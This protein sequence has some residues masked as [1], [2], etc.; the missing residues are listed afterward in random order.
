MKKERGIT[1]IALIITIVV[2]L[3][4]AAV[5][6]S[7]IQNDGILSYAINA[8]KDYNQAAAN[9]QDMLQGY[10]NFL[11]NGG[12]GDGNGDGKL[13]VTAVKNQVLS[14]TENKEVYDVYGNR[15]ILPAGFKITTDA[16]KVTEGIVI[17]H[18]T[19]GNQFVWI[20]VGTINH[21][22]ADS[23]ATTTL[24]TLGRYKF[25][26]SDVTTDGVTIYAG[27]PSVYTG[28]YTEDTEATHT[29]TNA[30]A[31]NIEHFTASANSKG[32]YYIGRYEAGDSKNSAI[33]DRKGESGKTTEGVL[34]CK[35][36][37]VP[38]NWILQKDAS[39]LCKGMY[40]DG[41]KA[42]GTGTFSSDLINSY[43][44]D[45]AIVFIQTFG[46]DKTAV[47]ERNKS[48]KNYSNL[49]KS[50]SYTKTGANGDEY[51]NINDMSGNALEWSTE[52]YSFALSPCVIR[53][54][55]YDTANGEAYGYT[56]YRSISSV[57]DSSSS[58]AFRPLLYV[59]L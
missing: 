21:L 32:G 41:Y 55:Y 24:I 9:E 35:A 34:V 10:L 11:N 36:N 1:L 37:Q 57:T 50:T 40:P 56:S 43:A 27:T 53:G 13:T 20:P 6:I 48:V 14:E 5:A 42:D 52:T 4:L 15:I 38:Y 19:D 33:A 8:A 39:D 25:S 49:N 44:W 7:S 58:Y 16:S 31:R 3:I 26:T 2:L 17:E 45:T 18:G 23:K 28:S 29:K 54:G 46:K 51:C 22:D 12:L 59:G 30:I 47:A